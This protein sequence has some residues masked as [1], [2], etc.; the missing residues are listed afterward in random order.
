MNK[1]EDSNFGAR[2]LY[3]LIG[4]MMEAAAINEYAKGSS[5]SIVVNQT[6]RTFHNSIQLRV[7]M[8]QIQWPPI[9]TIFNK[10]SIFFGSEAFRQKA[11]NSFYDFLNIERSTFCF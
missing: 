3:V 10:R 2:A 9:S 7:Y 8:C 1:D 4:F 11:E 5:V 6:I